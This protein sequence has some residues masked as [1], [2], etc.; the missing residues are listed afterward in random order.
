MATAARVARPGANEGAS[1]IGCQAGKSAGSEAPEILA[2][3]Q[4]E[5][6]N[7]LYPWLLALAGAIITL[8]A[9]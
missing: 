9:S 6:L 3:D 5:S 2:T 7:W 8:L 4:H 1:A